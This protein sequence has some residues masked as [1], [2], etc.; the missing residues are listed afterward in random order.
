MTTAGPE[1]GFRIVGS[2]DNR[3][4]FAEVRR[5]LFRTTEGFFL[6]FG[7]VFGGIPL[8]I[9]AA[10]VFGAVREARLLR[11]GEPA[12]GK[13]IAK[14][15]S[16]DSD[17]TSYRVFYEYVAA[18]GRTYGGDFYADRREYYSLNEGDRLSIRYS[19]KDPFD[20]VVVGHRG[21]PLVWVLPFLSLFIVVGGAL[22][23]VGAR[24]LRRRLRVYGSGLP[25]WGK[26]LG[27]RDDPSM[28][29][30][31]RACQVLEFEYVDLTGHTRVCR[32]SYLSAKTI[33]R[34]EGLGTVP[35]VYL[36][37]RADEADLDL[38]RL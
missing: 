30:N 3:L 13:V 10:L 24:R 34:L 6:L 27:I 28:R 25:A 12:M 33:S 20:A 15:V 7:T 2:L 29:V 23:F 35:V 18:D 22:F 8:L 5:A 14:R 31:G 4:T 36:P 19:A 1:P 21:I 9:A 16:S 17:S 11:E 26:N 38:D 37:D 32:S